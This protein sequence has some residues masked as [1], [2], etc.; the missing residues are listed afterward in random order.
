MFF[1][2]IAGV[3]AGIALVAAVLLLTGPERFAAFFNQASEQAAPVSLQADSTMPQSEGP[4]NAAPA[5][6][7]GAVTAQETPASEPAAPPAAISDSAANPGDLSSTAPEALSPDASS[8]AG[9]LSAVQKN[10][11]NETGSA[12]KLP[13]PPQP[14]SVNSE[15]NTETDTAAEL[16]AAIPE[17]EAQP[18]H[19][20]YIWDSFT[21]RTRAE[22]F[23]RHMSELCGVACGVEQQGTGYRVYFRYNEITQRDETIACMQERSGIILTGTGAGNDFAD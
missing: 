21:V 19:T 22:G 12:A 17:S 5:A 23:A 11:D 9:N 1:I 16:S 15:Q 13:T 3:L 2:R 8:P 10:S 20:W 6:P 7:D 4:G 18:G 14:A